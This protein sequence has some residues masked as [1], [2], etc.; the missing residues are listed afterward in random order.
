MKRP[1]GRKERE[2]D[3][4]GRERF[5]T[6]G[7]GGWAPL[8]AFLAFLR[9]HSA[10]A[11]PFGPWVGANPRCRDHTPPRSDRVSGAVWAQSDVSMCDIISYA[12]DLLLGQT[13][14]GLRRRN[15]GA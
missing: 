15:E 5:D 13:L 12:I 14:Q 2:G 1:S 9:D 10:L 6:Q 8:A 7:G 4:E 3:D 11:T